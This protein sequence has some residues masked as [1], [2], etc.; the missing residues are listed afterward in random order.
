MPQRGRYHIAGTAISA[1]RWSMRTFPTVSRWPLPQW[2]GIWTRTIL[3]RRSARENAMTSV[4]FLVAVAPPQPPSYPFGF[5]APR[6]C[7]LGCHC[8]RR[9]KIHTI[10]YPR[11]VAS[12]SREHPWQPGSL[13]PCTHRYRAC[14]GRTA[15]DGK[16]AGIEAPDCNTLHRPET[17]NREN[18]RRF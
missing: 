1:T 16:L 2:S 6:S 11:I 8:L 4:L 10:F 9:Q 15:D 14:R 13:H 5:P 7:E 18:S 17:G 12:T 3:R